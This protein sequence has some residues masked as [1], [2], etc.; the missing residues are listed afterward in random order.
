[1][2]RKFILIIALLACTGITAQTHTKND[3]AAIRAVQ[4]GKT[5][6]PEKV[7]LHFDN[8]AYYLGET[9]WFK[10]FV[11]S[12]SED[13]P[14][15]LSRVLY[16]ELMSPEGYVVKTE[17]YRIGDDGTCH[18]SMYMDPLFMSGYY[19]VRA[20]TRYMLNWGG[21]AIFSRVFPVFDK[22]NKDNWDFRNIRK[23]DQALF[24][25]ETFKKEKEPELKFYP[26]SGH[27]VDGVT[28]RVAYELTG[29]E[30]IDAYDEIT[31]LADGT[32]LLT[33]TPEH[34]G[35]GC[36][37]LTPVAGT[38]YTAKVNITKGEG[39]KV[40]L[41]FRL[42]E[43]EKAGFVL[44]VDER[45]DHFKFDIR[46]KDVGDEEYALTILHR[47]EMSLFRKLDS[48]DST[49][50]VP[51]NKMREGVNRAVIFCG[52]TPVAERLFFVQHDTLVQ[53]DRET[54]KLKVTGNGYMLHNLN[55]EPHE[56]ISITVE[57]EDGKPL[58]SKAGFAI[59]VTDQAGRQTTSWGY[60]MYT[61]Q[62]LGSEIK[63]YIPDAQQ[64][65]DPRNSKRKE[66]LDLVMLT[67]GWTAYN[68]SGLTAGNLFGLVPP[69][70][71]IN[72]R[73]E[74]SLRTKNRKFGKLGQYNVRRQP[75]NLVRI[76]YTFN[77][78]KIIAET[79]RTDSLGRFCIVLDDFTGKQTVA[80][81]P[82][83]VFRHSKNINY[84]FFID[85]YFSPKPLPLYYWQKNLGS[86]IRSRKEEAKGMTRQGFNQYLLDEVDV[87]A[88]YNRD[89]ALTSPISELRLDYLDEWEYAMDVT[90]R[91]GVIQ[92]DPNEE[93]K[94]KEN[95][96]GVI[97][98]AFAESGSNA[99]GNDGYGVEE[100]DYDAEN[101]GYL[102]D[103]KSNGEIVG[104]RREDASDYVLSV[105]DVLRS[106]Y[107]R[108]DLGWQ[109]WVQPVVIK[110]E[111]NRDSIPVTDEKYLHG[112]NVEAM[113]NFKNIILTSDS[114]KLQTID[115][116]W[117]IWE[118]RCEVLS[119]KHPYQRFYSGFLSQ[120]GI[121]YPTDKDSRIFDKDATT[122]L[123]LAQ[124]RIWVY[125]VAE[126]MEHP[127]QI[128]YLI[129]D[130]R[131]NSRLIKNDLSV[132]S[133]TRRYTTV[134][135]YSPEKQFYSPDYSTMVP[136]SNDFRR[137]LL[138]NPNVKPVDGKLHIE[139]YNSSTCNTLAV[140]ALGWNGN[141][142]Y[143]NGADFA[144]RDSDEVSAT[145][146]KR[147]TKRQEIRMDS[148]YWAKCDKEFRNAETY[149]NKKNYKKALTSYIELVQK[150]YPAAYYRIGEF[151]SKGLN[152]KKRDDLAAQFFENGAA[153]GMPECYYELA[154]MYR[155]GIH[156]EVDRQMEVEMLELATALDEPKSAI[157][158]SRY[159]LEGEITE[160]DT[161]RAHEL[162]RKEAI[163]G[164]GD[165]NYEL[166]R[167][168]ECMVIES[169]SVLG[170][171]FEC[172]ERAAKNGSH[173]ALWW[174]VQH[175]D[176]KG[177]YRE[178][179]TLAKELYLHRNIDATMY[180]AGCFLH[181]KG[182]DRDRRLA[183]DLYRE[184]AKAGNS[185]AKRI[186]EEW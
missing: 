131:D 140:D 13:S 87:K 104:N 116:S 95:E 147:E 73:G 71:G 168:M 107:K 144:T 10:A 51:K 94:K 176:S 152:L 65:F 136:D 101:A 16:V 7:Y 174:M 185:E 14:T 47:C 12:H 35:K 177:N 77:N 173:K 28:S 58:D 23:R 157:L 55:A 93:E 41:K 165:A 170:T 59:S 125:K 83:T 30:G 63:G 97:R 134:Q 114:R 57:R 64:Y 154:T 123:S 121:S 27:L 37:N 52:R 183:K 80:L 70:E 155:N 128:A 21:D 117:G 113:T 20:Y 68:W 74:F 133:S 149:Y 4:I 137:T 145:K 44:S 53:G 91:N 178:A 36:F 17:K 166:S 151:Y 161:T 115:G 56:K 105:S 67:N 106:V 150:G 34:M 98:V 25:G 127:N 75:N 84:A 72:I 159:L 19:E 148:A 31:I 162:L 43:V 142:I 22:V 11:T 2:Y 132:S 179:Y 81:S 153:L 69:E 82:N 3:Y 54:V 119:F 76:D 175:E 6:P 26:E 139:L 50:T 141:T 100:R 167:L 29:V 184:A 103:I 18:G 39:K 138:W 160:K 88:D 118:R 111:Y 129:P 135:G 78:E 62:L 169:D 158:L 126:D 171:P 33:T 108:Y 9:M 24:A 120:L 89:I 112:I 5:L 85:K 15:I 143:S 61:Y 124:Q 66:H 46:K 32:P 110:G 172:M 92:Y 163:K 182:V 99:P 109:N 146:R 8:T 102:K 79:F 86:S 49:M 180:L 45:Q 60:D 38:A 130:D 1:M 42:P 48:N 164:N 181:G 40:A 186:L 156:Y 96:G 90:Y 122:E